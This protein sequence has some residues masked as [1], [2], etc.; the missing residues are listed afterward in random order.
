MQA[1]KREAGILCHVSSLAGKYGIGTLGKE[2]YTFVDALSQTGVK[3]WQ[4]LPL[5]QTGY[6]DSPYSSV[7]C[8]SGNPYLIDLVA[9]QAQG[10]LTKGELKGAEMPC[11][12]VD[13]G[14]LYHTRYAVLRK[15]FSRFDCEDAHFQQYVKS[16]AMRDYALFMTA[17]TVYENRHFTQWDEV[18]RFRD[19]RALKRFEKE[20]SKEYLFW[21]FLQFTFEKQ[22]AQLKAY[23]N[24]KGIR[25]IGDIPLYVAYDSADVWAHPELFQLDEEL[26][27]TKV[28]GVPPDYFS[29]T[30]QLWGNPIYR[31]SVHE[32]DGYVWWKKRLSTALKTYDYVRIDHFRGLNE[33]YE[34]DAD[35]ENAIGGKWQDGPKDK[36]FAVL[37]KAQRKRIIAEDLGMI[38]DGVRSLLA[39]TGFPGMKVLLFAFDGN[40]NNDYLPHNIGSNSVCYTGTHDNSTV[41]GYVK[42]LSK[43]ELALFRKRLIPALKSCNLS[44]RPGKSPQSYCD[45]L[46]TLAMATKAR[47]TI[48]PIQ[49]VL[50]LDN[51]SRMNTPGVE[52]GNWQFRLQKFPSQK[53]LG[54]LKNIIESTGR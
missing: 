30:G 23:A 43:E 46:V 10:L 12:A 32:K 27:P 26:K 24:E 8:N 48:V 13:Y 41:A 6:G 11:G 47:F 51:S 44:N 16:G 22:W 39:R 49:D 4:I 1:Y 35:A 21:Q 9:L 28:A 19:A 2:A 53:A 50:G 38:D 31:W 7:C 15:A 37:T 14:A 3:I 34:I 17:K 52:S 45:A 29:A 36:L 42:S 33:Y 54:K 25:I 5:V 18:I 20:H 40:P